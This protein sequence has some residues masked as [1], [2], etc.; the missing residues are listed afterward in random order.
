MPS[1]DTRTTHLYSLHS[2]DLRVGAQ[3]GN[4]LRSIAKVKSLSETLG[5][6]WICTVAYFGEC[7]SAKLEST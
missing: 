1:Q 7:D 2:D 5:S 6:K 3:S 4:S